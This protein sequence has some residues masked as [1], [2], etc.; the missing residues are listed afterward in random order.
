MADEITYTESD[1]QSRLSEVQENTRKALEKEYNTRLQTEL[2]RAQQEAGASTSAVYDQL[3]EAI[4]Y[5]G[6]FGSPSEVAEYISSLSKTDIDVTKTKEYNALRA[7]YQATIKKAQEA[8]SRVAKITEEFTTK[9]KQRS[10]NDAITK[11]FS[12][13]SKDYIIPLEDAQALYLA[14]RQVDV[15][16]EGILPRDVTGNPLFDTSG[17]IRTL[18]DD[19]KDVLRPYMKLQGGAGGSTASGGANAPKKRSEMTATQKGEFIRK[20][21]AEAYAKLPL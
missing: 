16:D 2:S 20:N 21:G 12:A 6:R 1:L 11:A 8:E 7:E 14:K 5:E 10:V 18:S 17:N 19:I 13:I 9:E 4:G 15:T 3:A